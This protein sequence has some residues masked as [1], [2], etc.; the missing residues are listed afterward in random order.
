MTLHA[1]IWERLEHEY[2]ALEHAVVISP[3]ALA[4]KVLEW[5]LKPQEGEAAKVDERVKYLSLEQLIALARKFLGKRN[6]PNSDRSEAYGEQG[7]LFSGQLQDRYPI[8][9]ASG[10][11]PQYKL[12]SALTP[13]ER[14]WNVRNL[15]KS[16][17]SRQEHADALEA[18]GKAV[19]AA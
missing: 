12:R 8:P 14:A 6:G 7:V 3:R 11:E 9:H 2:R 19:A 18:E 15:R 1:Q 16:A 13:I 17:R 5:L 10:E 4:L